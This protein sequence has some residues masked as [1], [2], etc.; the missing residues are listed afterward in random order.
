MKTTTRWAAALAATTLTAAGAAGCSG[1]AAGDSAG[2]RTITYWASNQGTSI[3]QDEEVLGESIQRFTEETGIE[4]ELEV[5]PWTDLYNRILTAISSGEGPDVL[6][7]GNTWAVT[8]QSSGAFLPWEGEAL[9]A[10]GGEDRFVASSWATGG[11]AGQAPT[12]VP[13]YG[14]AYSMYYNTAM[15]EAAGITEPP[16]TWDEFLEAAE[17]LTQDTDG[18]GQIDQWGVGL[19]G[20]SY[21]NNVHQAFIRGLQNGGSLYD[22]DGEPTFTDPGVVA[23][24]NQWVQLMGSEGV[25]SPSN[26]ELTSGTEMVEDFA[27]GNTA[28]F[29]DQAPS[30][31]LAARGMEDYAAAPV[32]MMTADATGLEGTQSHV[33]GINVSVLESSDD[34][35]AAIDFVA[36]LT[37]DEEQRFLN[38]RFTALPVV[39][40]AYDDPAFEG[41]ETRLKQD[42]LANHAQPMPL[43]P[44]EGQME[45]LVGTAIKD[46]FGRIA[47]GQTVTEDDVRAALEAA[48]SQMG[49]I[50]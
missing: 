21:T 40:A 8:L 16:A 31:T 17:T 45:T 7:I 49:A 28:M 48:Q 10:I 44:T 32:P 24:V 39:T 34:Q 33:A 46:L 43:F 30:K 38:A 9:E 35:E 42:I 26:A 5:I 2:G 4:V 22:E 12:S 11:A 23:G 50:S 41:E 37:S 1:G 47:Q 25:V 15:F 18:D 3:S 19:A 27:Q 14:L 20:S 6:N 13:L 36:H 29:F